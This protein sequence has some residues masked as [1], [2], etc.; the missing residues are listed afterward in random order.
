[1]ELWRDGRKENEAAVAFNEDEQTRPVVFPL[2]PTKPGM[3]Q[4]ELRVISPAADREAQAY[5]FLIE[6]LPPGKRILYIENSL[7]FDFK[8][9]R[10]AVVSD[11]N[12]QLSAFVRWADGRV[13]SMG[14][15]GTAGEAKLDF[16]TAGLGKYS[17]V[18]LGDLTADALTPE[19]YGVLKRI[20]ESR[21]RV[22][23]FSVGKTCSLHSEIAQTA[24]GE[25]SPVHL[26]AEHREANVPVVPLLMPSLL[27]TRS[28]ARSS[29]T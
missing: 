16:S 5:P 17:V 22:S 6:A 3:M 11:R 7:G 28:S 26:P 18:M 15:R 2:A 19:Q 4:Y 23:F 20:R 24:L 21:R 25:L 8:F 14:E 9:L 29:P 13:V 27:A 10:R 12:L 1:M